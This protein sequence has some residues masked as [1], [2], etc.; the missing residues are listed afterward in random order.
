MEYVDSIDDLIF[1]EIHEARCSANI[2]DFDLSN[3]VIVASRLDELF[4]R[5]SILAMP[6]VLC[7]LQSAYTYFIAIS[8]P[9]K[10]MDRFL[11]EHREVMELGLWQL[12]EEE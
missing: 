2:K 1:N 9:S 3:A 11:R 7:D 5:T 8:D 6:V 12:K 10:E 4:Q